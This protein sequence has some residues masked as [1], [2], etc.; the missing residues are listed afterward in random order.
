MGGVR[1]DLLLVPSEQLAAVV[2]T[3]SSHQT[4]AVPYGLGH[5]IF[6][7]LLPGLDEPL[8]RLHAE[9]AKLLAEPE[10]PPPFQPVVEL[11]GDWRGSVHTYAGERTLML[12]FNDDGDVH[13]RLDDEPA[14]LVNDVSF[15][16]G[17]LTGRF[18][19]DIGTPDA[20]RRRHHLHLD[21]RLRGGEL[22]GA[23]MAISLRSDSGQ[24]GRR[25]GNA[26][27]H[28]ARLRRV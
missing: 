8:E 17:W 4:P 14:A 27:N 18:V 1:T 6:A 5:E 13:A 11:L 25:V 15:N 7:T 19:G 2:L 3:N 9:R 24:P 20:S 21:L 26:L 23:L 12:R 10:P 22:A 16:D 28:P